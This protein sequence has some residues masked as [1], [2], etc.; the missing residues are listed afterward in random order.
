VKRTLSTLALLLCASLGAA[1]PVH[2][3]NPGHFDR[4]QQ[5]CT[6]FFHFANGTWLKENPIPADKTSWGAFNEIHEANRNILKA[7]FEEAAKTKAKPGSNLQKVGDFYAI[8]MDEKALEK[9]GLN[10]VKPHLA[11]IEAIKDL[12]GLAAE[13]GRLH[14][15]GANAAFGFGIGQDDKDSSQYIAQFAQ[16]GLGLPDRDYYTNSDEKSKELRA[17]YVQH[18]AKVFELLGEKPSLAMAHAA[19]VMDLETRLAKASM[20]LVQQRDPHAIYH[21][22]SLEE[23]KAKAPA[24]IWDTYAQTIGLKGQ[25][26]VLVRQP[27]FF[28][29]LGRMAKDTSLGQWKTYLRWNF[30]R[31]FSGTLPNAFGE[32]SFAFYGKVLSGAKEREARWKRVQGNA[33]AA[34]GEAVGQLF[35]EKAFSAEAKA[36]MI[37]MV[38]DLKAALKDRIQG[39]TWMS[40]STKAQALGKLAAIKVKIGYPDQWRDY[41]KL[42]ISR[43]SYFGNVYAAN[44]FESRRQMAKLGQ[45]IDRNEWGMTPQMVNA[46]Y[47]PSMNEICFPAGILQA[48][49]FDLKADAAVNYGAIGMVIGHELTHGFDDQG[50][51]YDAQGNLKDWWTAEDAKAYNS[52]AEMVKAQ[53][54]A[55]EPLPGLKV[56]GALTLGENIADLG[57]LKIAFEALKKNWARSGKPAAKDGFTPEQ[58]FFLG[59]AQSWRFQA[60]EATVRVRVATDV[61]SP[62]IFRVNGPLANLPEF[63]EAFTCKDGDAL[64]RPA[65]KRPSIW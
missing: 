25:K 3:I 52:R 34:L 62:A 11:R 47:D 9:A 7:V 31:T 30:I 21:K 51:Q 2:G 27:L 17:K 37:E 5:P 55:Y 13:I 29:E 65:D 33:D 18:V 39:L 61:H 54:D 64:K 28:E 50:R 22:M 15:A 38:D 6:D 60:R 46:Y 4:A 45:P 19:V 14:E 59:Y 58:R 48:P 8:G 24:F 20:T 23:L 49:F 26:A 63:F 32:E 40:E 57:G 42:S 56:N 16:G 44:R 36:R 53:Y 10:P 12:K 1:E 43:A 41:S 35:V